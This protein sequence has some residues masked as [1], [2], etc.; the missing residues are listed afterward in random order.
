MNTISYRLAQAMRAGA[1]NA[2]KVAADIRAARPD[3]DGAPDA[4]PMRTPDG[5]G[6][7]DAVEW[8]KD[9]ELILSFLAQFDQEVLP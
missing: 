3:E 4:P 9:A 1:D 8:D 6:E 5:A 2:H 7:D